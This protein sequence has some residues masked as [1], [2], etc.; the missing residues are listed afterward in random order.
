[1]NKLPIPILILS[2]FAAL[3]C[4]DINMRKQDKV[5]PYEAVALFEHNQ[6]ARPLPRGVIPRG[7]LVTDAHLYTGR[8]DGLENPTGW[9]AHDPAGQ[10]PPGPRATYSRDDYYS[11]FPIEITP[12]ILERGQERFNIY[13]AP[14][15]GRTGNGDGMIV[16]RGFPA[17]PSYHEARLREDPPGRLFSV[18]TNGYGNM[19]SY[20][21]RVTPEDRWA[22]VAYIRALQ[23]AHQASINEIPA[24]ERERL[25]SEAQ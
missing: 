5:Q 24:R 23:Q 7:H 9:K 19:Y 22:I 8:I 11:T 18:I 4:T 13:C 3:V 15:H 10:K 20:A 16:Q 14:C 2:L 21:A 12:S 6:G 1:M 17:P 25:M